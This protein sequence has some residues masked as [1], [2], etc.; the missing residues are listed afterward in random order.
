MKK[1]ISILVAVLMLGVTISGCSTADKTSNS[2][3]V[4]D[5][6][7]TTIEESVQ[8]NENVDVP[9]IS[10]I[11]SICELATTEC[12]YHNVAKSEKKKGSGF[13][14]IGEVDRNFWMEY[15]GCAK[16]GI[17]ASEVT[18]K[19]EGTVCTIT[20][21]KAKILSM[22]VDPDSYNEQSYISSQDSWNS[23]PITAEDQTKT[24]NEAQ[25]EMRRTIENDSSLLASAQDRAK[26]LIESYIEQL[27]KISKTNYTIQWEY[28]EN[29]STNQ[30]SNVSEEN[31]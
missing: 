7:E 10:Q 31:N 26:K 28:E 22:S 12:Y 2:K 15:I 11:H 3:A 27:K 1:K 14:H 8:S 23:N 17:E 25:D 13:A 30:D 24:I 5:T 29:N 6:A 19:M 9:E 4:S 18:M 16:I 20:I 21:P